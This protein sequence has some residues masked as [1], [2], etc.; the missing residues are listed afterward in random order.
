MLLA[1]HLGWGITFWAPE[2]SPPKPH[3][4]SRRASRSV[5]AAPLQSSAAAS[6]PPAP[7]E[8]RVHVIGS[9]PGA[10][11]YD[12]HIVYY[13]AEGHYEAAFL[14]PE[15][16]GPLRR[17]A[18]ARTVMVS[19][20]ELSG[21]RPQHGVVHAVR[22]RWEHAQ[23]RLSS[24]GRVPRSA[25]PA[26]AAAAGPPAH[27]GA[28]WTPPSRRQRTARKRKAGELQVRAAMLRI[29]GA[30]RDRV[31]AHVRLADQQRHART[32]P[33]ACRHRRAR[34]PSR[35]AC[36]STQRSPRPRKQM[37]RAMGK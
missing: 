31:A 29:R 16:T 23:Q 35:W 27:H 19:E 34:S 26:A 12:I 7:V 33:R 5:P 17:G 14:Q 24:S 1:A 9:Y 18:G 37:R 30:R 32:R 13:G 11:G 28:E 21:V 15:A 36:G 22:D 10:S 20:G 3:A 8:K 6:P 2:S 25:H 4:S